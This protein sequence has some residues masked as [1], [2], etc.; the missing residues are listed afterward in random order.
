[1]H[2]KIAVMFPG[3][4]SQYKGMMKKL[5]NTEYCVKEVFDQADDILRMDLRKT[6]TEGSIIELNKIDNMLLG[7]FV[8]DVA[9]YRLFQKEI[10]YKPDCFM[11]HSLGEYAALVAAEILPFEEAL[12]LVYLRSEIAKEVQE[13]TYGGMT[14]CK[15]VEILKVEELCKQINIE[16]GFC[17]SI[18][19]YNTK[20]QVSIVGK[21]QE[22]QVVE[23]AIRKIYH[24]AHIIS[25]IGSAPYHSILMKDKAKM[26]REML[27][28][29][30]YNPIK[31]I[32]ISNVTA[33]PYNNAEDVIEG[34]TK[35]LY[36]PVLWEQTLAYGNELNISKYVE[37]GPLNVLKHIFIDSGV[38][39][40]VFTYD[41]LHD[42]YYLKNL[43]PKNE[44][45][46]VNSYQIVIEECISHV[47][48][49]RNYQNVACTE[50]ERVKRQYQEMIRIQK[51]SELGQ[52]IVGEDEAREALKMLYAMF[53]VRGTPM[54]ERNRRL[55][56]IGNNSGN[57][58]L[59][60]EW[61]EMKK[62]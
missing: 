44:E 39:G 52:Y 2:E 59:C 48:S 38:E 61:M 43:F 26:L 17:V 41:E 42:R 28:C 51:Q 21:K 27:I 19:C 3:S 32:V 57:L 34:L 15:G 12:Q 62:T 10:G 50:I 25:L 16:Q 46:I 20:S 49:L 7:V 33:K 53:Q 31:N 5:Y 13:K 37:I 55:I 56:Q 36:H 8:S 11:G 22:R 6:V 24:N 30:H 23:K 58:E 14:I 40:E 1:M 47:R 54:Q 35:Q 4:G 45:L 18:G 60:M 29:C 9:M